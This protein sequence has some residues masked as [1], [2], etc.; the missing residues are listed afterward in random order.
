MTENILVFMVA[1]A[2][3]QLWFSSRYCYYFIFMF[4]LSSLFFPVFFIKLVDAELTFYRIILVDYGVHPIHVLFCLW[5]K[6]QITRTLKKAIFYGYGPLLVLRQEIEQRIDE[7]T[8][9]DDG[10]CAR[11]HR[12]DDEENV[13]LLS[14]WQRF[15]CEDSL[16]FLTAL[17]AAHAAVCELVGM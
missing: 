13:D 9:D 2:T 15:H 11:H 12:N 6:W 3:G 10:I 17:F 7:L 8:L 4:L 16:G 1:L 14:R 5:F